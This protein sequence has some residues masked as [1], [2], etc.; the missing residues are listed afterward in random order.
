[1]SRKSISEVFGELY[2]QYHQV[3]RALKGVILHQ[4]CAITKQHRKS[5]IRTLNGPPPE[6]PATPKT[7]VR[8]KTYPREV[9]EVLNKVW[10]AASYP[11]GIR[12]KAL[13]PLW[14]PKIREHFLPSP[15]TSRRRLNAP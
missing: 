9:I 5:V 14:L 2:E 6:A 11:C 7:R 3:S 4:F 8:G 10:E 1:M 13:L 12:L 15:V